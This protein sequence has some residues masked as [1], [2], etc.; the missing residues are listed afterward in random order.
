MPN[1]D[2]EE[3]R[4]RS[5]SPHI[6]KKR[7]KK[8]TKRTLSEKQEKCIEPET[9]TKKFKRSVSVQEEKRSFLPVLNRSIST[10][11]AVASFKIPKLAKPKPSSET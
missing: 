8:K 6:I 2:A 1:S 9:E 10:C 5:S 7:K 3:K 4:S 11:E